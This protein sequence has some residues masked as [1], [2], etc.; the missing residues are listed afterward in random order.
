MNVELLEYMG[1]DLSVIDAARVSFDK[2]SEWVMMK[3]ADGTVKNVLNNKD[4]KLLRYLA[5]NNHWTPFSHPQISLRITAPLYVRSQLYKHKVG[6]TEN[7]VSR[8]YVKY[9][10]V[11]DIPTRWRKAAEN[12]KQGSSE[13][14]VRIDSSMES[15]IN[16]TMDA[17]ARLY[18]DLLLMGVCAEQARVILP[19][20]SETAWVWTGSLYFFARVCNLRLDPHAQKETRDVA[21]RISL[22]MD[23][24]FPESWNVLMGKKYDT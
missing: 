21:E 5:E 15:Q 17:V 13:Q 4:A 9:T 19:V 1:S 12:V 20:C 10:P 24:L 16:N 7:E 2:K 6:G 8:R 23:E 3:D 14:L 18:E 11:F 22:I